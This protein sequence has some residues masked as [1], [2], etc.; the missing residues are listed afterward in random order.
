MYD[1]E[2][3]KSQN[4]DE[5]N[6]E[7][8]L[9]LTKQKMFK[10]N[11]HL[12]FYG[13]EPFLNKDLFLIINHANK[14]GFIT[15][16]TTNG[17]FLKS[18]YNELI[19]NPPNL[20]T[21]SYYLENH[22]LLKENLAYVPTNTI[23]KLNFILSKETAH[24]AKD[25]LMLAIENNFD[26]FGLDPIS[27]SNRNHSNV[28]FNIDPIFLNLKVDLMDIA[29]NSKIKIKWPDTHKKIINKN[30][31]CFFMWDTLYINKLGRWAPCSE[32]R[33]ENYQNAEDFEW[34]NHWYQLQRSNQFCNGSINPHCHNCIYKHDSSMNL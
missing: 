20:L 34:N 8:Y 23:K 1:G 30:T 4:N 19:K 7:E 6:L 18:R 10:K 26:I 33:I 17:H 31:K 25:A 27:N 21:V 29:K 5:I 9:E 28:L 13:G 12:G 24:K 15:S 22:F 3:N 14:K 32:W 2:L 11:L 16:I